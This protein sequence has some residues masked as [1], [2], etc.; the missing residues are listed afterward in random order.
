MT[1]QNDVKITLET[2]TGFS[3]MLFL[4]STIF[5]RG[6]ATQL[7]GYFLAV[8]FWQDP[9]FKLRLLFSAMQLAVF[10][11]WKQKY[12]LILYYFSLGLGV[13]WV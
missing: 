3:S 10:S 7:S 9:V 12:F 8:F 1:A 11:I 13:T 4:L 5:G 2:L 6:S